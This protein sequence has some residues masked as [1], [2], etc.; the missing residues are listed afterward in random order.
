MTGPKHVLVV[1]TSPNPGQEDEFNHWYDETHLAEVLRIP[2]VVSAQRFRVSDAQLAP[3]LT[4]LDGAP[5]LAIYELD[6]AP[7]QIADALM[8]AIGDG[9]VTLSE[10]L[11]MGAVGAW[12]FSALGARE[13]SRTDV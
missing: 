2:G 11:D 5:Y 8:S 3:E 13:V 9:S 7:E 12:L 10:A 1:L 4:S 6:V